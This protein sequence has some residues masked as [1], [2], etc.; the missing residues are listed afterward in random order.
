M[1]YDILK[2][3]TLNISTFVI[4]ALNIGLVFLAHLKEKFSPLVLQRQKMYRDGE[5][6]TNVH[7]F[8]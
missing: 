5:S 1:H 4:S 7:A 3:I 8:E 6:L 2:A